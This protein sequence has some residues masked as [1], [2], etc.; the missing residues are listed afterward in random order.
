M[1]GFKRPGVLRLTAVLVLSL[2]VLHPSVVVYSQQPAEATTRGIDSYKRGDTKE[3]IKFLQTAV[4]R[5]QTDW[6][7]WYYLGVALFSA[8]ELKKAGKAFETVTRLNP[9]YEPAR[10]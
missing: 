5:N 8:E 10:T 2:P 4:K 1:S 6:Q 3:A 9:G 7:A